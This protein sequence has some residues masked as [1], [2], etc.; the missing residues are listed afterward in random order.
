LTEARIYQ[1]YIPTSILKKYIIMWMAAEPDRQLQNVEWATGIATRTIY[2]I[3]QGR[4][5]TVRFDTADK[6]L[7]KLGYWAAWTDDPALAEYYAAA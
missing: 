6:I 3:I 2:D 7:V 1:P 5:A 4:R